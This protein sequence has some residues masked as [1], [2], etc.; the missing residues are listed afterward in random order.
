MYAAPEKRREERE[1]E[2]ERVCVCVR[3]RERER[4]R[5]RVREREREKG[6]IM[7]AALAMSC[8]F[9]VSTLRHPLFFLND[10][11]LFEYFIYIESLLLSLP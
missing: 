2:R 3:E 1:R 9:F 4:E 10:L 7:F 5:E 11:Y 6:R 8:L